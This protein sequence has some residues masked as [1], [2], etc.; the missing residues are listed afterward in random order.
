MRVLILAGT[1]RPDERPEEARREDDAQRN[2]EENHT[3]V[4]GLRVGPPGPSD[5][6]SVARDASGFV[7][8]KQRRAAH[9]VAPQER[10][11][12]VIELIGIRIADLEGRVPEFWRLIGLR[13]LPIMV[14][15]VV[16]ILGNILVLIDILFIFRSDRRC[17]H[18]MI[19]GTIVV[20]VR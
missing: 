16:P 3:H 12:I 9:A 10:T 15:S 11:T 14:V 18:D 4:T 17:I 20:R 1:N 7:R 2:E 19:A 5:S 13:Y 8:S 6:P